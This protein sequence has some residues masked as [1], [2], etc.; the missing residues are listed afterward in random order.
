MAKKV[1]LN[2]IVNVLKEIWSKDERNGL[3]YSGKAVREA[4]QERMKKYTG[5]LRW[6]KDGD[7]F[8]L[9]GFVDSSAAD[10]YDNDPTTHADLLLVNEQLPISTVQ[11]DSYGSY[12][13]TSIGVSKDIVVSGDSM[14]IPLRYSAVRTSSGERLNMGVPGTL[15]IQRSVDGGASWVTVEERK[16]VLVS[17]DYTDTENYTNVELGGCLAN[18]SQR[19]RLRATYNYADEDGVEKTAVS[20]YLSV[21]NTITK[22]NLDL[23]CQL[24]YQTPLY[25][26]NYE[27]KGFPIS[28]MVYGAVPKTLHVVITGG[29]FATMPEIQYPLSASD[30]STVISKNILDGADTYKLLKHGV[31]TVKAWLTCDDGLGGT[32]ES[33]TVVRRFMMINPDTEGADFAKP[34]VLLQDIVT[35]ADNYAQ[36][37]ICEYAVF[38]PSTDETGNIVNKG[39]AVPVVFYLTAYAENFPAD[40]PM[41]YIRIEDNVEPGTTNT[42]RTTIEIESEDAGDMIPAYFRVWRKT[43]DGEVNA[44]QE[45]QNDSVVVIDV[46]NTE[47]YAPKAGADF[48]LN[49]KTRNN[50]E[51]NPYRILNA[52]ANGM[53]IPSTWDGFGMINDGWVTS[54]VDGQKVLRVPAG[55]SLNFRYNPFA[56]FLTTADSAMTMEIDFMVRNVTDEDSPILGVYETVS[57]AFRGLRMKPLKGN[58]YV[59]SNTIDDETSFGWGEGVRTHV[60]INIHNAVSPNKGDAIVPTGGSLDTS[61]TKIALVRVAIDGDIEREL[62][63]SI[64]DGN[65]FC[66]GAMSNGGFTIGS[67]GADIDIY[68]IRC[69]Q[70]TA[71]ESQ[72][73]VDNH[74]SSLPTTAEKQDKKR[75]N[76]ILTGGKVDIAKVWATGKR[77]LTWHGV[78]PY[79]EATGKQTGWWEIRQY[80]AQGNYL[81]EYSGTLCKATKSLVVSRQG[82]TAN[83]YYYSNLQTK[84]GDVVETIQVSL[85]DIHASITVSE[86]YQ[87]EDS[88]WMVDIYG[89]NLGKYDPV[90]N[91]AV[92][93]AYDNATGKVTVPDG[94]IDGN[95]KYRG[96]GYMVAAGTPLASKLVNKI[97]VASS[98][99]SHLTG[100]N[101]LYN[102]LHTICVGRMGMQQDT[103]TA[104]MSKYTEPFFFFT[105]DDATGVYTFRGNCTF[106]GGKMDKPTWGYVK[107][108]HPDFAMI[109][110]SDNNYEL[111]DM[112]VPF[113]WNEEGCAEAVT[114]KGG[115]YEGYFYN[116]KQ[117][118]DFDGGSTQNDAESTPVQNVTDNLA[119]TWNF[120]YLHAPM[121]TYYNGTFQS[122]LASDASKD[123]FKKVW[124]TS[125]E[126]AYLLKRYDHVNGAWVDAGLWDSSTKTWAKIDLRTDSMTKA[127]YEAS[128]NKSQYNLLNQEFISAIVADAKT[129]MGWYFNT[130]S[131]LF[132]YCFVV[133]L[134]CGTDSCSKNTYY[135]W[136]NTKTSVT[137]GDVTKEVNQC[138]M[139]CDDVDTVLPTDNNGRDTKEYYID[140]MHPYNDSDKATSKYEGMNN[141]L[142]NLI[143]AMY[144]GTRE[145]QQMMRSILTAME[146]LVKESD[147]ISG[148]PGG[149][150]A[151]VWGCMWKYLFYVQRYFPEMAYNET[152]RIRYEYPEMIGFVSSGAGAR[153]VRPITQSNGSLLQ[154][155]LQFTRRRL[156]YIASYAAW[157]AFFDNKSGNL[158]I[159]D[160]S[161]SFSL[162]AYHLPGEDTSNNN[163]TFK[164]RPHQY[165]WP[166]GIM[167]QTNIDPHVRVAPGEEFALDLGTTTS[168]DTGMSVLGINYYRSVGNLG[169]LS[170]PPS[171]AL[172]VKGSRMVEFVANPTKYYT[173]TG[174]DGV[175]HT[176]PA[177]RPLNISFGAANLET[178][179]MDGM[180]ATAGQIDLSSKNRLRTLSLKDTGVTGVTLP[181]TGS[182]TDV[183]LPSA[184]SEVVVDGQPKLSTLT[185]QGYESLRRF[186]VKNN[187]LLDSYPYA[188]ELYVAKP[189]EL[190]EVYFEH[191]EWTDVAAEQLLWLASIPAT[192]KGRITMAS[193]NTDRY[194]TLSDI[195]ALMAVYGD[196][197]S[198]SNALRV[199]YEILAIT[200]IAISG[201][202]LIEDTGDYAY[203]VTPTPKA[204][205]NLAFVDGVPQIT[206]SIAASAKPYASFNDARSGVLTVS[207]LADAETKHAVTCNITTTKGL[208]LQASMPVQIARH[209]PQVGD[210]CYGDGTVYGEWM[211][212]K[213][214]VGFVIMRLPIKD[215][216]DN[217][218]G[219]D[220]RVVS[221][222]EYISI[223]STDGSAAMNG[224]EMWGLYP[225]NNNNNGFSTATETAIKEATGLSAVYDIPTI[226]NITTNGTGNI[227][228]TNYIDETTDDG[229]KV[230]SGI[231]AV[232]DYDGKQN[233]KLIVEHAKKIVTEYLGKREPQ[234]LQQLWDDAVAL[235][236]GS[237]DK[238]ARWRQ[239]Y[240]L[241][242]WMCSLWKPTV[243]GKL[244]ER[245]GI[246][247]WYLPGCGELARFYNFLRLGV[248]A[249]S[250]D[251]T[252][253][254]EAKTPIFANAASKAGQQVMTYQGTYHWSSTDYSALYAWSVVMSNGSVYYAGYKGLMC[255]VRPVSAFNFV[256]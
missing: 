45:A 237:S 75:Q 208:D 2:A 58:I 255:R 175:E 6:V 239:M 121:L 168:N 44:M 97:N 209:V 228:D 174:T 16:N 99:Q 233:T 163:Y 247:K 167:G 192:L 249:A 112:R 231:V 240:Y 162:Q 200:E 92:A 156:V 76:D 64:T 251:F 52:R 18:G 105:C 238:K 20:V 142:M 212:D 100:V 28:Y 177:F 154:S 224:T 11:G 66:T 171:V 161:D 70:N 166:T 143:E 217:L 206:W 107:K 230:F 137:I 141:V 139:S 111:T 158:G 123:V 160:T 187:S 245:F 56:Q 229:Y 84:M 37:D 42:L 1:S 184:I 215:S 241:P 132:Y 213:E 170:V 129:Y 74:I 114:Y 22:T 50:S 23:T 126:D 203:T 98:M 110:G 191:I 235:Q 155:E 5:H 196:I 108:L 219:Y 185:L 77:T 243:K 226:S 131:L 36:A 59:K 210:F 130:K 250:A 157:G 182:L 138:Y 234:T 116:G 222:E 221:K 54:D 40:N 202:M 25:A 15:Q 32:I 127:T 173:Y 48:L 101:N 33:R 24:N 225:D 150:K 145:M 53:E 60:A 38:S 87:A 176:E 113:T 149:S 29:N 78:E 140:R 180:T 124:C 31:R 232:T 204:G 88:S 198:D 47:S 119:G 188:V 90:E 199:V 17:T 35:D 146:S 252:Q 195:T 19:I 181:K 106:G 220:V 63:Y 128:A 43:E 21:G 178:I 218:T 211:A 254:K 41:Q 13:F 227:N 193:V 73:L 172:T 7:Y 216:D 81:P 10:T 62:K 197:T 94:W 104:R 148:W 236:Q 79:H 164:V 189:S 67:P 14:V 194:L 34:Y 80:D 244:S 57:T 68:S 144:E 51:D 103:P 256:L 26:S 96:M 169:D 91:K 85:A 122:F 136:D 61:K 242:A 147:C 86:P 151:S 65:E 69:Y 133:F 248:T 120:L 214:L 115:D 55:A 82:S 118:L 205:N 159:A 125:G 186:V 95:G 207:R 190:Q 117:C 102:D 135:T 153:G 201:T 30:D 72:E 8:Y 9:Q 179:N 4:L 71:L 46:D 89:G 12:L 49:P 83:T 39:D 152:A 246:G 109:E 134:M 93:Y 253:E 223:T 27:G 3:P 183:A 165:L